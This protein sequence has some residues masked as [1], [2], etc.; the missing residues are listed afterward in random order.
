MTITIKKEFKNLI[1]PL[2]EQ[3]MTSLENSIKVHGVK[4]P[5]TV[6]A[7][8]GKNYLVD[9]HHRYIIIQK[10]KIK[11]YKITSMQFN[12]KTD[13]I[14]FILDFQMARR[15]CTPEGISYL[16]G[17]RYKNE[18]RQHGGD[19]KS[20]R[21]DF[22]LKNTSE[23]L[24]EQYKVTGR[25]IMNDEKFTDAIDSIVK[26]FPS[27]KKQKE[28]KYKLLT[29]ESD[30]SKKD[31]LELSDFTPEQIK[32]VISG[33]KDLSRIRLEDQ[34]RFYYSLNHELKKKM[35]KDFA[36]KGISYRRP[37][38]KKFINPPIKNIINTVY[39]G[40]CLKVMQKMLD[41]GMQVTLIPTSI[42]YNARKYYG[43]GFND[44]KKTQ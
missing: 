44:N 13:A 9:G 25:T 35:R 11:K 6:W 27:Y 24:G 3:E 42:N 23:T 18:K 19:R 14:N 28:T 12:S 10:H 38:I 31:I 2:S 34:P 21:N 36:D 16:R 39:K 43:N 4:D 1:F 37:R 5:L 22:N 30:L 7:K 20:T 8:N 41:A 15:N 40:N 32:Q 33:E 26:I 17:L 29:R